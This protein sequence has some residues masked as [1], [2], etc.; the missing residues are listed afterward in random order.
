MTATGHHAPT[1]V[2]PSA[3]LLSHPPGAGADLPQGERLQERPWP[4]GQL[5]ALAW[6]HCSDCHGF[7]VVESKTCPCVYESVF[8]KCYSTY[9]HWQQNEERGSRRTAV[10][11]VADFERLARK[12]VPPESWS[13][14][15][16]HFILGKP[17]IKDRSIERMLM[18]AAARAFRNVQP[19][20]LFPTSVYFSRGQA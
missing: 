4:T 2:R 19:Y 15:H 5:Q 9:R 17:T 3:A 1:P 7:G 8:R 18:V 10:E 16:R 14:F 13:R 20:A 12:A 11:F 6:R